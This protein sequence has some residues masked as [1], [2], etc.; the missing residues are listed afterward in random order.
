VG[1]SS[2]DASILQTGLRLPLALFRNLH[3]HPSLFSPSA[4]T[5]SS[6][7]SIHRERSSIPSMT[8]EKNLSAFDVV[9]Y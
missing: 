4:T 1:Q 3:I 2:S 7:W 6:S 8:V 5:F 9:Q